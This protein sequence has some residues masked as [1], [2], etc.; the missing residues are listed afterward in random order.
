MYTCIVVIP[1]PFLKITY[2]F[3]AVSPMRKVLNVTLLILRKELGQGVFTVWTRIQLL[4]HLGHRPHTLR[5]GTSLYVLNVA[6]IYHP[7]IHLIMADDI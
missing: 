3:A 2:S 5:G 1:S 6:V 4:F 7:V